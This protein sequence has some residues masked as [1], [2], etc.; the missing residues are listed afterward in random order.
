M[1]KQEKITAKFSV[2]PTYTRDST[3]V[4]E[5]DWCE[6]T[7]YELRSI[8]WSEGCKVNVKMAT[9]KECPVR[10]HYQRGFP[11]EGFAHWQKAGCRIEDISNADYCFERFWNLY[12]Y[13]VGNKAR[14]QKKWDRLPEGE[15]ILALAAIP[16]YRRFCESKHIELAYPETYIDQRRWENEYTNN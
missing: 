15:K 7:T 2:S 14:V 13:K 10:I 1:A 6:G 8:T 9:V 12:G 3:A 4:L 16:K 11:V 5:Y